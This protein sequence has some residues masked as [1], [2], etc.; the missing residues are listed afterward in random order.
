MSGRI[1]GREAEAAGQG[2]EGLQV[3]RGGNTELRE[4]WVWRE[5]QGAG[6]PTRSERLSHTGGSRGL[7]HVGF[8]Q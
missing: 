1:Q 2:D 8:E 3:S 7:G 5:G 4:S 6:T